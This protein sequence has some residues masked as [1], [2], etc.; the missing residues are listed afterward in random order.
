MDS[1]NRR[2]LHCGYDLHGLGDNQEAGIVCPECGRDNDNQAFLAARRADIVPRPISWR[3]SGVWPGMLFTAVLM[4]PLFQ[5]SASGVAWRSVVFWIMVAAWVGTSLT[6]LWRYSDRSGAMA[7]LLLGHLFF[8]LILMAVFGITMGLLGIALRT[9]DPAGWWLAG[10]G[11]A[12]GIL[13]AF[14]RKPL[15]KQIR[16]TESFTKT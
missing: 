6:Y 4:G 2:C 1:M 8:P 16:R 14:I 10:F 12:A 11:V 9:D 5:R 3:S 13:V 7:A 15:A